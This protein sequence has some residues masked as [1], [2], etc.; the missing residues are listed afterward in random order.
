[1]RT[2]FDIGEAVKV[3]A[4]CLPP[5]VLSLIGL[6]AMSRKPRGPTVAARGEGAR[7]AVR[8]AAAAR[9]APRRPG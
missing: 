8:T 9:P 7:T 5:L 6:A 1:M 2:K 4:L 3:A